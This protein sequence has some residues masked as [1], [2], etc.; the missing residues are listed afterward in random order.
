MKCVLK[1]PGAKWSRADWIIGH[2][3]AHRVYL[4]PWF[5]SGA[6]FFNKLAADHETVN[7]LDDLV[8]NFFTV[9]RDR[10]EDLARVISLTPYARTEYMAAQERAAGQSIPLTGEPVED[11]RRFAVRCCQS[12]GSK[13]ADR[14][15]W[16]NAKAGNGPN[17][18]NQWGGL[19]DI[20][21]E[22]AQRLKNAQIENKDA[23]E[24]ITGYN[25]P[26][27]LIYA[28][29]PYI[30][31]T[32]RGRIYRKEMLAAEQHEK[33]L[34]VLL[35]HSGP[36]VLSGYDNELYNATLKGWNTDTIKAN[37][38]GGAARTEKLWFNFDLQP[39]LY[40]HLEV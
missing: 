40:D 38:D 19:P 10:P 37:A 29:P 36:V 22:A 9:I 39:T 30:G 12:F 16:R 26:D 31:T 13:T 32:R 35:A 23:L 21:M 5:G 34:I 33:M 1:Y 11:A 20:I 2:F 17:P 15:G 25:S 18:P 24:L 28:D 3:P 6:V 4:E 14:V 27:C 8:C 7:D